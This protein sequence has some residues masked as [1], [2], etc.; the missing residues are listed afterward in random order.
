MQYVL[1]VLTRPVAFV[2]SGLRKV[3]SHRGTPPKA[4]VSLRK[5]ATYV[6]NNTLAMDYVNALAAGYPI[7]TGNIEVA[8]RHLVRDRMD[9]SGARWTTEGAEAMLEIR[10]LMK[11]GDWEEYCRFHFS[12][13]H[14][15]CYPTLEKVA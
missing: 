8:C 15:R 6:E 11:S 1:R 9:I 7:A 4:R 13:E 5:R 3:A 12:K 2:V 14:G 10:A